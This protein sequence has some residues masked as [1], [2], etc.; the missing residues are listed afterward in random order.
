M[1]RYFRQ[2]RK[3]FS[4]AFYG[5]LK[6]LRPIRLAHGGVIKIAQIDADSGRCPIRYRLTSKTWF[7]HYFTAD[8]R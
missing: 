1:K 7:E 2:K 5:V 3:K 8:A 6:K 4:C